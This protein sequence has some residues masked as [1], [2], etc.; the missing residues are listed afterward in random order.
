MR[1]LALALVVAGCGSTR[2]TVTGGTPEAR[3]EALEVVAAAEVALPDVAGVLAEGGRVF[4]VDD[5][6]TLAQVCGEN[7]SGCIGGAVWV[8]WP[9][10]G[11]PA[12]ATF[13]E[14]SALAHELGHVT[15]GNDLDCDQARA[16]ERGRLVVQ[17]W[18]REHP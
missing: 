6:G 11:C 9:H 8:L 13:A 10:P 16:E 3:A 5:L 4:I 18:K 17:E 15:A 1:W 7:A 14:C 2:W 12:P